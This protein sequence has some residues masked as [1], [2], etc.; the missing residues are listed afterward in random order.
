MFVYAV[1]ERQLD[2]FVARCT[3]SGN[4]GTLQQKVI[5]TCREIKFTPCVS[6]SDRGKSGAEVRVT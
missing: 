4:N 1:I 5:S 6:G 3:V 2:F